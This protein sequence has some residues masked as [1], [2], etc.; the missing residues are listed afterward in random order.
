[1][2]FRRI[3]FVYTRFHARMRQWKHLHRRDSNQGSDYITNY[4]FLNLRVSREKIENLKWWFNGDI[5]PLT[6]GKFLTSLVEWLKSGNV[7]STLN[8][9]RPL[10]AIIKKSE[11][12]ARPLPWSAVNLKTLSVTWVLL[13]LGLHVN[14][15][16][17]RLQ[18]RIIFFK[19][20]IC[21][22]III[23]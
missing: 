18:V 11:S 15:L 2:Q 5:I 9:I 10:D 6:F 17:K 23:Y 1:M 19:H 12:R 13:A 14:L 7:V 3:L 20:N 16:H 4:F 22:I 21:A 8:W